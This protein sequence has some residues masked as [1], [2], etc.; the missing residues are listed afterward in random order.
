MLNTGEILP[1]GH[2][3]DSRGFNETNENVGACGGAVLY[4]TQMIKDMGFFDPFFDTG[5]EDAE[6]G[7]RAK[8]LG[9]KC[10]YVPEAVI[11][12]KVSQSIK[13]I[14]NDK[15]L[16]RVQINIFYTFFKLMPRSFLWRNTP[17]VIVKY[18][19]W[20]VTGF[21]AFQWH[22][23]GLHIKTV[24]QFV[25]RDL[26]VALKSRKVF[27]AKHNLSSS[28]PERFVDPTVFF[29]KS[30]FTRMLARLKSL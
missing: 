26:N 24:S 20:F 7:L 6:Y 2:G 10:L 16:Q 25:S 22:L 28:Y 29:L 9:Y 19:L 13:K 15:Y 14:M 5:Y 3:Q 23:L 17:V 8:L 4:D 11:Y 21:L 1:L 12:H 27:L 30:D 18:L